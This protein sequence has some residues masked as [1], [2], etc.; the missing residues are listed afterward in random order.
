MKAYLNQ[1]KA[2]SSSPILL[3]ALCICFSCLQLNAQTTPCDNE[4]QV[5]T[6]TANAQ[7]YPAIAMDS[8]GAYVVVWESYDQDTDGYGIYLQRYNSDGS[9]NGSET[10]VNSSTTAGDQ[11][12]PDVAMAPTGEH[13]VTWMSYS[14]DEVDT[15]GIYHRSYDAAG[16]TVLTNVNTNT[17]DT[18]QQKF[19]KIDIGTGGNGVVVWTEVEDDSIY[20][21]YMRPM[22]SSGTHLANTAIVA[23][24][25]NAFL[26]HCDVAVDGSGNY[27]IVWQQYNS[28]NGT[29][30]V[31]FQR[32]D[33]TYSADGSATL[34]NS[35]TAQNQIAPTVEMDESGNFTVAWVSY[36]QD[37]DG[38]GI[39]AQRFNAAGNTQGSEI[40]VSSTSANSQNHPAIAMTTDGYFT[41]AWTSYGQDG[42]YTGVYLQAYDPSGTPIHTEQ[43][44][45]TSTSNFQQLPAIT[46]YSTDKNM[47]VVWQDGQRSSTSTSDGDSY[48]VFHQQYVPF[49]ITCD[50]DQTVASTGCTEAITIAS[51]SNP[52]CT[53]K[54]YTITN[55]FNNTTNA[56]D[57]YPTG[58]TTVTFTV[59]DTL[60]NT[61]TCSLDITVSETTDPTITCP[62]SATVSTD[63][64]VCTS[65]QSLALTASD[66]CTAANDL[67]ITNTFNATSDASGDYGTGTTAVTYTATDAAGNSATCS[68]SITVNDNEDPTLTCPASVTQNTDLGM[69]SAAVTPS[70]LAVSDNC[71]SVTS[72]NDF[73]NTDSPNG[74]YPEGTTTVTYTATDNSSNTATCS[75]TVTVTDNE[76]PTVV[77]PASS[78]QSTTSSSCD[79]AVTVA[80]PTVADN[81]SVSSSTNDFNN[82]TNASGTYPV[83]TTTVVYTVSDPTGNTA[84][85][86]FT[87]TVEDDETPTI[88]CPA[89]S[90]NNTDASVC[91]AVLTIAA[92]TA[93][94]NCSG[95]ASVTNDFNNTSNA[96]GTYTLGTTTVVFTATDN[97]GNT[98]TCS[99]DVTVEDNE[100]PTI[101]CPS[102]VTQSNDAGVCN[103]VVS[104]SAPTAADNCGNV[105]FLNNFNNTNDAAGTYPE[106]T[107]TV[108][109]TATDDASNTATCSFT[110]TVN[111]TEAPTIT[112]PSSFTQS[113]TS[114]SCDLAVTVSAP[115][116]A[117]NCSVDSY[118]N[119][120]NNTT[121]ASG[122]YPVGTTTVVFTVSDPSANAN[123]CSFTVTI[124][125]NETPTI[126]CPANVTAD[127]DAGNC[128]AALTI[129]T[130]TTSDNCSGIA[131]TTNDFNNTTNAS[132]TYSEGTTTVTFTATDNAGNTATC[133]FDVTVNDAEDPT[134]SCPAS[135]TQDT[136][137]GACTAAVTV[138]L[139][140]TSDN[141][142]GATVTNSFNNTTNASGTY[143]AGTT[144]ASFTITDVGGN[145]ATCSFMVTINDNEDPSIS[146]PA[147]V[148]QAAAGGC[149]ALIGISAPTVSDNCTVASYSNDMNNGTNASDIYSVGTTTVT[150]TATDDSGNTT[151][152]SFDVTI[153]ESDP[154]TITCP[155]NSTNDT[156]AGVCTAA[157]TITAPTASDACSGPPTLTND[158][159]N[160]ADASDTYPQGTTT[161]T[162]TATDGQSNTATCSFTVTVEDNESPTVTCPSD[163]AQ[164]TDANSA[165]AA[166]TVPQPTFSD[167]C[168]ANLAY[169]NSFNFTTNASGNYPIGTTT[170]NWTFSD[171][172]TNGAACSMTVTIVDDEDPTITCPA[173]ITS[174]NDA[175]QCN[176]AITVPSPT[177]A[178]N[179]LSVSVSNDFNNTTNAS[180]TY[181]V[182][183]TT[184]AWTATDP[185]GNTAT[186]S[187]TI[188]VNDAEAPTITC[189]ANQTTGTD[190][191][192]CTANVTVTSA[193]AVDNCLGSST[194][195]NDFNNTT[196]ASGT[197]NLG[198]TTVTWTVT[199]PAGNSAT[200]SMT[201]TVNDTEDP[202]ASCPTN[203]TED[204]DLGV[205]T[206]D[207]TVG[208]P[209][210]TDNCSSTFTYSNDFN[211]TTDASDVYPVGT[212][213]V[214]WTTTDDAGNTGTCSMTVTITDEEDPSISCPASTTVNND[215]GDCSAAVT[216]SAP[217]TSDN[218]T[219]IVAVT[220]DFNNTTDAS[221]TYPLGTTTVTFTAT[222]DAGNTEDCSFTVTVN[223]NEAPSITCPANAS[224]N[225]DL[226]TCTATVTI[227]SPTASDNC[228]SVSAISLDNDFNNTADASGV[229]P[230]STTTVT[231]TATDSVGNTATC[232]MDVVVTDAQAP[233]VTCPADI[234]TTTAAASCAAAVTV[235]QPSVSDNC[236]TSFTYSNDF[237]S[238]SNADDTYPEGTTTVVWTVTDD[239]GNT[240][241]CSL[242]ITVNDDEDPTISCPSSATQATDLN[243]C[244]AAVTVSAPTT[245]D[246]CTIASTSNDFNN[247]SDASDTYPLGTTTVTFTTTD[248]AGNTAT[249]SFDITI[250]DDQPADVT[251]PADINSG[252]DLNVCEGTVTISS[253][254]ITDNCTGASSATNDFNNTADASGTYPE[255]STTVNWTITD[256]AGNTS[257]C[258]MTVTVT[259]DQAPVIT[260]EADATI[261]TDP[262]QCTTA[263]SAA[264]PTTLDNCTASPSYA[265]DFN[266]TT[267]ASDTY[268]LGTTDITWTATDDEGNTATCGFSITV[269]DVQPPTLSCAASLTVTTDPG[270]CD[271]VVDTDVP[272]ATDNCSSSFTFQNNYNNTSDAD[273]TYPLGTT[274]VIWSTMDG[275][276]NIG[277]CS[278]TVT[279][280]DDEDPSITCPNDVNVN[281]DPGNCSAALNIPPPTTSDNC[282]GMIVLLNDF[283]N[284]SNAS[285]LYPQGS[286]TVTF[287][288]TD[289]SGNMATCSFDVTV[290]DNED[291]VI[292]C[293]A[294]ITRNTDAG[295]AT[296]LVTTVAPS[297]TDNC[298]STFTFSNDFNNTDDAS[299]VY[300]LGT[301]TVTWTASEAAGNSSTCSFTITVV[302]DEA[303]II[304][305]PADVTQNTDAGS[306]DAAVDTNDPT[307]T[308]NDPTGLTISNDF[309]N[310]SD[311]DD[312]YLLGT[313]T[314]TWTATDNAGNTS[315]CEFD[316]TIEDNEAPS[317]T[318][319]TSMTQDTDLG[320]CD[321]VVTVASPTTSDNCTGTILFVNDLNNTADA[322]DTYN[323]GTTTV[324][325]TATDANSNTA[326]CSF[327]ITI[328]DNEVPVVTCPADMTVSNDPTNCDAIVTPAAPT[329]TDNCSSTFT[330]VNNFNN[331]S[332]A[333]DT[334]LVGATTVIWTATDN[335]GNTNDCSFVITVEDDEAPTVTCPSSMTV[336]T[337]VGSCDAA[338][339]TSDPTATDNCSTTFTFSNDFNNTGNADD[340]Y[341]LGTTTVTWT[342]EDNAGNTNSCSFD[343]TVE[344]N[345][346]PS[347]AC[348]ANTTANTDAGS[349]DAALSIALPTTSDNCTGTVIFTNDFNNT[350]NPSDTYPLGSTTV[351]F[352]ATDASGNTASCSFDV[353]ISDNEDPSIVCPANM[354]S[355]ADAG[356]CDAAVDA[357]PPTVAD[358]CTA[359]PAI[360][361]DFNNTSDA[362]DTYPLGVTVV[363]WTATDNAGNTADCSF[364]ITVQDQE[365]PSLSCPADMTSPADNGQ[366]NAAIS[367]TSPTP[368]DNCTGTI[369]LS[370]DFNNTADASDTYN[371]GTTT[372][373][374]TATDANSNVSTCALQVTVEDTQDPTISC[375]SD[376]TRSVFPGT[377]GDT[378]SYA[379]PTVTD[380][381]TATPSLTAGLASG[382]TFPLGTTAVTWTATDNAGNTATCSFDVTVDSLTLVCPSDITVA[383]DPGVCAAV[384]TYNDPVC[385]GCGNNPLIQTA[386]L[387]SGSSFPV[388]MT[389]ESYEVSNGSGLSV[390]CDFLITVEDQEEPVLSCPS[391]LTLSNDVNTCGISFTY[392]VNVFDNCISTTASQTVTLPVGSNVETFSYTDASGNTANCSFNVVVEDTQDPSIAC[393][394]DITETVVAG[395]CDASVTISAP[396]T[397]DNCGIASVVNDFNN[398]ADASDTYPVG[399]TTVSF[400]A[401]DPSGNTSTCSLSVTVNDIDAPSITCPA[402]LTESSGSG[403]N[404]NVVIS[405]PT[406]SDNC[407]L[408]A[409]AFTNDYNNDSDAS[410]SY[411]AGNTL[412]TY[413]ATDAAGNTSSCDFVVTVVDNQTPTIICPNDTVAPIDPYS[414][415]QNVVY[416]LP[417]ILDNCASLIT[418]TL[419]SGIASGGQFPAGITTV[420]YEAVDPSGNTTTCSFTVE[421]QDSDNKIYVNDNATGANN[422]LDWANAFRDLQDALALAAT[423]PNI[424]Q[425]WVAQGQYRTTTTTTRD[426]SFQ[427]LDNVAIY[428]GFDATESLLSERADTTGATTYLTGEIGQLSSN[429][430]NT[431]TILDATDIQGAVVDGFTVQESYGTTTLGGGFHNDNSMVTLR[432]MVFRYNYA[433]QGGAVFTENGGETTIELSSFYNNEAASNGGAIRD[434]SGITTIKTSFFLN[435]V[436]RYG[437][438][439]FCSNGQLYVSKSEFTSNQADVDGAGVYLFNGSGA[440]THSSFSGNNANQDGGAIFLGFTNNVLLSNLA[441]SGNKAGRDGGAISTSGTNTQMSNLSIHGNLAQT[442]GGGI[443]S[444]NGASS[445]LE[446]SI[447]YGNRDQVGFDENAQIYNTGGATISLASS[448]VQGL[449]NAN[450]GVSYGSGNINADPLFVLPVLVTSVPNPNGDLHLQA[451]SPS[452]DAGSNAA[453]A[454]DSTD[455]DNDSD[456]NEMVEQDLEG[457]PRIV[458]AYG[459]ATVDMGAYES[460]SGNARDPF[461]SNDVSADAA[462]LPSI[463]INKNATIC[464]AS[465]I[466][467][468]VHVIRKPN[469]RILL[470]DL[471]ANYDLEVYNSSLTLLDSSAN[472]GTSL[473]EV[474]LS[475]L[476]L[477]DQLFIKVTS[478]DGASSSEG[479][480]LHLTDRALPINVSSV[481]DND[482]PSKELSEL[483][484]S[485]QFL[486]YPNPT[487]QVLFVEVSGTEADNVDFIIYNLLGQPVY[488]D[489][490]SIKN[491]N[492]KRI[493]LNT[494]SEGPY[495]Y[496]IKCGNDEDSGKIIIA[497]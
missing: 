348:P 496:N 485:V 124:E 233:N 267:D 277:T 50:S 232:S 327:D 85:C 135:I 196:N 460:G 306:C 121:N 184:V 406:I 448:N 220:N 243:V 376:I 263:Y 211:N 179:S 188:T 463:G 47:Y 64:G 422:G 428:G 168:S 183:T 370:N 182:G 342:A 260:C 199:D 147:S 265:N 300:P 493:D 334:Y 292:T 276:G 449:T 380:N 125:D 191:G 171:D 467:W 216:I 17:N 366:C 77:C 174:D 20:R 452:I 93:S 395:N 81:C 297:A 271:A 402:D 390:S 251:C 83:G 393:P 149:S 111:D 43:Q 441:I 478:P 413:T 86:S 167:N 289:P 313:T 415:A 278:Y 411:P 2:F 288:A 238:T 355:S 427:L 254:S 459:T 59:T 224:V 446:N 68:F 87:V 419:T 26:G 244:T 287:T 479:Y 30:E 293:Q 130:P 356:S 131:S 56:S 23:A 470:S 315:T 36:G 382:S 115:T 311:A 462:G 235:A 82:T 34:I 212:T 142:S 308:D 412:V 46:H 92:P 96:G 469:A 79:L 439:I 200:C 128:T 247:T 480:S 158:F 280:Q 414:C 443:S 350:A 75:F 175:G 222:D 227:G 404:A 181:D 18:H 144:T 5:N 73:T 416:D 226:N 231:W 52:E 474:V 99:F 120:F 386:G 329:A 29:S 299:D 396:T 357:T 122:T 234:T 106:G 482:D 169:I 241:T 312:T 164:N 28:S 294:D 405:L 365:D 148:T 374:F 409:N 296:A 104:P 314:V 154:P 217:T 454:S 103:A 49:L 291:P 119:D 328:E 4:K 57:N 325:F 138:A 387:G 430:D 13:I 39:Y 305:C 202:V 359:T 476:P 45:N 290:T 178:D 458:A 249:C 133:S 41:I 268:P 145:T 343:I 100:N 309:N 185:S 341:P 338:V 283:N 193:T 187:M 435:N 108:T 347:I 261:P 298:H 60:S 66:N 31:Y 371:V 302:D 337:D 383:N 7:Q 242:D 310:T 55:D 195:V 373:T 127:N 349:C 358:N 363:T 326:T 410:D 58:T 345:E 285:G 160:S 340:T 107:T 384:V 445:S 141:C 303:P 94:D 186:C 61:A 237:N 194:F 155:A 360:S 351:T 80:T 407:T 353:S 394:A 239:A 442:N 98:A 12:Y 385:S 259:D 215:L 477:G 401:A 354:T 483:E 352:N 468:Y 495:F 330:F 162:F 397:A 72:T 153:T 429:F 431:N 110:V 218:C 281:T 208:Q 74:T 84:T 89:S 11:R 246:N 392:A 245:A 318:C 3:T 33:D 274:P 123:T 78:T 132:G 481:K 331:T 67:T 367:I 408:G 388:G 51:P 71:P 32:Y 464:P 421:V 378:I 205:C 272:T 201:V 301:T 257:T 19:P 229:Y 333:M 129:A 433:L 214:V 48:G 307:V 69:C 97:A 440:V 27:V 332:N 317:I 35:T 455:V 190:A 451:C 457:S 118:S 436:A 176:A 116:V 15:W 225:T 400:T 250:E 399:T 466:D 437:A 102:S 37:G 228:S 381:C 126:S 139:P 424:D 492:T 375:P 275:A 173:N 221:D 389:T 151:T 420:T 319:P 198:S 490:W 109:Y 170:V 54:T 189:P 256:A 101:S 8:S 486:L 209:T 475:G 369:T 203:V 270:S 22:N 159:N 316:I 150:F 152:C 210:A 266:N 346:N 432:H 146:C 258:S 240:S 112:C 262:N 255:G 497:Y 323:L 489:N 368:T 197:Y 42:S 143:S 372:V 65:T 487:K 230:L 304:T 206:G 379:T 322:S 339:D 114:S 453:I 219:A 344:D 40:Q 252:T 88:S 76:N 248:D 70:G 417:T 44:V 269:I 444:Y 9:T 473:D 161:V 134:I 450:P 117:D 286:T 398:T 24:D 1:Y 403:C 63:A 426:I 447:V 177:A 180:D 273:D 172:A 163:I 113:T 295:V 282:T 364:T 438:S 488:E 166:V 336:T 10:L 21:V 284:M 223:D 62:S 25:T 136:D 461:E 434:L 264:Q 321:A 38:N 425:I 236:S 491:D 362:D 105:T 157:L 423:C 91:T 95:I 324:T 137:N 14:E 471:P 213:T 279:V 207:A 6:T 192:V 361:N 465:D 472:T 165:T 16:S 418:P 156:D 494:L 484:T 253:P 456:I 90:T 140:T 204:N 377:P 391:D 53:S 320:E 335:A